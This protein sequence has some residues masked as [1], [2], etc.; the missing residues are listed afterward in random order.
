MDQHATA[1]IDATPEIY[2]CESCGGLVFGEVTGIRCCGSPMTVVSAEALD[3]DL[4]EPKFDRVL[5]TV[6]G[7][8]LTSLEIIHWLMGRGEAKARE[9]TDALGYDRS[10]ITRNLDSLT[11]VGL[12]ERRS[13]TVARGGRVY[14]YSVGTNEELR[15]QFRQGLYVWSIHVLE[16]IDEFV[17]TEHED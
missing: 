14:L 12:V 16:A 17:P 15:R 6:F 11:D 8:P 4:S 13:E 9:I 7:L 3:V 2:Q 10:T 5:Q 1:G